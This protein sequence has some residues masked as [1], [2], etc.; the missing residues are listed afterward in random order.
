MKTI[1]W[2][3]LFLTSIYGYAAECYITF[4]KASC[5]KDYKIHLNVYDHI[6]KSK[7]TEL[8]IPKSEFWSR[9]SF[10]CNPAEIIDIAAQY[11][12]EIWS[13]DANKIFVGKYQTK[14]PNDEPSPGTIWAS[15]IC[16]PEQFSGI[17]AP[18]S[19]DKDCKCDY[20]NIP[21]LQNT[22]IINN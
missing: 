10:S 14:F 3:I 20:T 6:T 4:V 16:F 5:W 19:S 21:V 18:F 8:D 12:P 2:S 7:V 17:N 13:G 15:N 1:K 9:K 22:N 11:S